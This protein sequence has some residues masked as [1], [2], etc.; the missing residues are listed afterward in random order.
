MYQLVRGLVNHVKTAA[1]ITP[2]LPSWECHL[3]HWSTLACWRNA[4][5]NWC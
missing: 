5:I 2:W 3:F 1:G 4:R